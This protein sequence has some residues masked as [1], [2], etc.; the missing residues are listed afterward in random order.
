LIFIKEFNMSHIV[1]PHCAATNRVPDEKMTADSGATCGKCKQ[2]L[3]TGKPIEA[4]AE[5][6]GK[7]LRNS[8]LPL[9]VDF[10]AP[11]CGPCRN[12]AP[13]FAQVAAQMPTQARFIKVNTEEQQQLAA[14]FAIRS[15]P[16]LMVFKGGQKVGE[17]SGALGAPQFVQWVKQYL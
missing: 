16:T 6:F 11:W 5:S 2:P 4:T 7:Q 12:F 8:D 9:I 13:T 10:W 3:F 14:Q 1:C 15:I 17:I